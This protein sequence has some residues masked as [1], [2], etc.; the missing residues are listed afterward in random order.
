MEIISQE[1][2]IKE[3]KEQVELPTGL[4]EQINSCIKM[5]IKLR[6]IQQMAHVWKM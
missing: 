6:Y 3:V 2:V 4:I 1:Q 5:G